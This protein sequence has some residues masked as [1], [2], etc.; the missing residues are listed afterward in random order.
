MGGGEGGGAGGV[1]VG[2]RGGGGWACNREYVSCVVQPVKWQ[3]RAIGS[4]AVT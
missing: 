1:V 4:R 2:G 3:D